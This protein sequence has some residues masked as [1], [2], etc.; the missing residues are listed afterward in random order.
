[1]INNYVVLGIDLGTS[2]VRIALINSKKKILYTASKPYSKGLEFWE[3]WIN[4]FK[5]LIQEVPKYLKEKVVSCS[6]AGTSGTLLA[7]KPNGDPLGKAL[8]YFISCSDNSEKIS[9]LFI[10]DCLGSSSSGS[11]GRALKLLN[12]YGNNILLRHQSDWISG[13]L[14]NNWEYGEEGNNIRM[15]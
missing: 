15:G 8:P 11:V 14:L 3:D 5:H 9:K 1:M 10:K 2:G 12:L 4:C 7:C 13:W 6:I